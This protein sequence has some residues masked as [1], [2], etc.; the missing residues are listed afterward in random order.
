MN[1][2][3]FIRKS[4]YFTS[5]VVAGWLQQLGTKLW[6]AASHQRWERLCSQS[7]ATNDVNTHHQLPKP[8]W[9]LL[10]RL[11][12]FWDAW[13]MLNAT[14]LNVV[15]LLAPGFGASLAV[16]KSSGCFEPGVA[17]GVVRLLLHWWWRHL[18]QHHDP[19]R[20][21]GISGWLERTPREA[22]EGIG[23]EEMGLASPELWFL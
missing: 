5:D 13:E 2:I 4:N 14:V 18:G 8:W 6:E 23:V 21:T 19:R 22:E 9:H 17:A 3:L 10:W 11:W 1:F 15:L 16:P 12:S 20:T 7:D